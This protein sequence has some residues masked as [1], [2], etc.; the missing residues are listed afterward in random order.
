MATSVTSSPLSAVRACKVAKQI[1]TVVPVNLDYEDLVVGKDLTALIEKAY[2][3][4]G[5]GLLTVSNVPGVSDV[6]RALLPQANRF[7]R[8]PEDVKQ[9]YEHP[10][11]NYS[12]GWSHGKE[13]FNGRRDVAKGSFYANPQYDRPTED[14][15]LIEKMPAY[16]SP[17]VWPTDDM[18]E[19]EQAF[20]NAGQLMVSIGLMIAKQCDHCVTLGSADGAVKSYGNKLHDTI[21]QS[22]CAKGRLLYYFPKQESA[23]RA[24]EEEGEEEEGDD[25][26]V[27]DNWCGW[28]NDHGSLTGL[29]PAMY[30]DESGSETTLGADDNAGLFI[31][32][33]D[34]TVVRASIT[35]DKLAF[36]IGESAQ[37]H[38]G[39]ALVATPHCVRGSKKPGVSRATLAVFMQP[40][41]DVKMEP[42]TG[43]SIQDCNIDVLEP[44]MDFFGFSEK[45]FQEYYEKEAAM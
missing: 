5:L 23:P 9:K 17:N 29:L 8:L 20:K 13:W 39:G 18:P 41:W 38:S 42:L 15:A 25:G 4:D 21:E 10:E 43:A 12:F 3:K 35:S 16:C 30:F 19:L 45:R 44:G 31:Q 6:R 32:T 22:R 7:A 27:V 2:G 24:Q 37:I 26:D 1:N 33:R 34:G 28:H 36:Q 14:A 40:M 11:S